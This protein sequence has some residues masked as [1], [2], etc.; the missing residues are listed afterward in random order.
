MKRFLLTLMLAS[1]GL[2][3]HAAGTIAFGSLAQ[4]QW[5]PGTGGTT[6]PVP[7]TAQIVYGVFWGTNREALTLVFPLGSSSGGLIVAPVIYQIPGTEEGQKVYLQ[8]KG[9]SADYGTNWVQAKHDFANFAET[10]IRQV[11]LAPEVGPGTFIW[12]GTSGTNPNR[13]YLLTFGVPL[14]PPVFVTFGYQ[15]NPSII[16]DEGS[17]GVVD[18]VL[19]VNRFANAL[20]SPSNLNFTSTAVL[21][22]MDMTAVAGQDYMLTNVLVTFGPGETNRQVGIKVTGDALQEPDEQFGVRLIPTS[23]IVGVIHGNFVV[24]IRE[25]RVASVRI[26]ANHAVV[27]IP[28]TI[29]QRYALEWSSDLAVWTVVTGADNI[30]GTGEIVQVKDPSQSCCDARFYRTQILP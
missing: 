2:M 29:S 5:Y 6:V 11:T 23:G 17:Q 10:D 3:A 26:E 30:A 1:H 16:V 24:T 21:S 20:P 14:T 19:T 12:Q 8:V 7:T 25:A 13:F 22:T 4:M 15:A 27:S 18:V 9:W 28:T